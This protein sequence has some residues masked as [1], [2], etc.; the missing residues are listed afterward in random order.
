MNEIKNYD[1]NTNLK[2]YSPSW[3]DIGKRLLLDTGEAI[4]PS[5]PGFIGKILD[6]PVDAIKYGYEFHA[7]KTAYGDTEVRFGKNLFS[8][9]ENLFQD[10]GG[11]KDD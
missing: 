10:W 2:A 5:I 8:A 4:I 3:G 11:D 9:Q 6:Y 1:R 7:K